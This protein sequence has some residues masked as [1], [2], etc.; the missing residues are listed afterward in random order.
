MI[1]DNNCFFDLKFS[2]I[3]DVETSPLPFLELFFFLLLLQQYFLWNFILIF[4]IISTGRFP[5]QLLRFFSLF[6]RIWLHLLQF[7]KNIFCLDLFPFFDNL[8]IR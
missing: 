3:D 6:F 2:R 7:F 8:F 5:F 4:T 1:T